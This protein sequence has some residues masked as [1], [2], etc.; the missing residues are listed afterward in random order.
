MYGVL[1][2]YDLASW[3]DSLAKDYKRTSEQ[4]TGTPPFMAHRLLDGTDPLH[5]YRHDLEALFYV[6]VILATRYEIGAC[7]ISKRVPEEKKT[8]DFQDWFD[9]SD[10]KKLATMKSDFFANQETYNVSSSFPGF[11][12]W[13]QHLRASL[14][15][16]IQARVQYEF[17]KNLRHLLPEGAP[18][19]AKEKSTFDYET[20]GGYVT[21][22]AFFTST[23]TL[24]GELE[25]LTIRGLPTTDAAKA[26]V[27]ATRG[28]NISNK[29]GR[30]GGRR[31]GLGKRKN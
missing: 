12:D 4:R 17:G 9:T 18:G 5:L 24:T 22:S 1:V 31:G 26:Q 20:L 15:G 10:Y 6:M 28:R 29:R 25:G 16:G 7:G 2:D 19:Q 14:S 3:K 21:H 30:R 8:L 11:Y 23:R 27:K 13:L